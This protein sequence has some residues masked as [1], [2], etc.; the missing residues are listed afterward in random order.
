MSALKSL[1]S[2]CDLSTLYPDGKLIAYRDS[3]AVLWSEVSTRVEQWESQLGGIPQTS[4]AVHQN[5]G[6]ELL[7]VLLAIWRLNKIAVI[8]SSTR[9]S[10]LASVVCPTAISELDDTE[11]FALAAIHNA[12]TSSDAAL[13]IYTSGSTGQAQPCQKTFGQLNAEIASFEACW[14]QIPACSLFANSVSRHHMYGLPFALLWPFLRGN[15]FTDVRLPYLESLEHL[16]SNSFALVSSP[17]QLANLPLSLNTAKISNECVAVFSAGAPLNS[18]AAERCQ[19][20]FGKPVTEI[21]GSTETGAIA[22]RHQTISDAWQLLP[23]TKLRIS[24]CQHIEIFSAA[25]GSTNNSWLRL[26][27]IGEQLDPQHFHLK[28]RD[29][30]IVKVGAKRISLNSINDR[31]IS[32]P[33]VRDARTMLLSER[34]SRIAAVICLTPEGNDQLTDTGRHNVNAVLLDH[35]GDHIET[36]AR[37]RYWRYLSTMPMNSQG[38]VHTEVLENL[39]FSERQPRLPELVAR[40]TTPDDTCANVT[41]FVPHQLFYFNGHF[42]GNAILPGVVQLSWVMH[43]ARQHFP[44]LSKFQRLEVIKFQKIIRPGDTIRLEL[45]WDAAKNRLV[46][47]YYNGAEQALSSG[48]IG[49]ASHD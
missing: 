12:P 20:Y 37:P 4:I 21:Y 26:S 27:D 43:F 48:R 46:F 11:N 3:E 16:P 49:F 8:P 13:V 32:H 35:L 31:L 2:Y 28:G 17:V 18:D 10:H 42:P 19:H 34:K 40:N 33:W 25:A 7:A 23:N 6:I 14:G 30:Q 29:D 9:R 24:E 5:S 41:L 36:I 47:N 22:R 38:K 39:F 1:T 44:T 15:P 45:I